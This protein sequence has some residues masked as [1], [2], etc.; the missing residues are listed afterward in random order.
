MNQSI[1]WGQLMDG[2]LTKGT[3]MLREEFALERKIGLK[4]YMARLFGYHG[5]TS[6]SHGKK[7]IN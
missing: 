5:G 1:G 7:K 3:F 4:F 2:A 6:S